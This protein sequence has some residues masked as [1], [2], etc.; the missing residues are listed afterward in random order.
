MYVHLVCGT[1][2]KNRYSINLYVYISIYIKQKKPNLYKINFVFN[3]DEIF[4]K[5]STFTGKNIFIKTIID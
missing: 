2:P 5:K 1:I 4:N 3:F